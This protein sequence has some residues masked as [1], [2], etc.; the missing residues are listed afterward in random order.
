MEAE[1][2]L[3]EKFGGEET[4]SRVVDYFYELVLA[5][6]MVS[7]FFRNSDMNKQRKHQTKFISFAIGGPHQY[8]GLSMTKAHAGMN[9]QEEH[10][11][12]IAKHLHDALAHFGV[13]E[14]DINRVLTHISTLK[15]D[16]LHK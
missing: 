16:V 13:S 15:D 10:F 4:I 8:T 1:E 11:I 2:T 5:D 14:S 6:E 9:L 12:A 7:H 3:Y